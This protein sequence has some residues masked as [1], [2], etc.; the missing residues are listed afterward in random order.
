MPRVFLPLFAASI[1]PLAAFAQPTPPA[2]TA[3]VPAAP[4]AASPGK[5]PP[6][7][8]PAKHEAPAPDPVAEEQLQEIV[9]RQQT[10]FAKAGGDAPKIDEE[11]FKTQI[12]QLSFD[13]ESLLREHPTAK[14]YA[15]FGYFLGKIDMRRQS[16]AMLL[17]SNQLDPEQ[18]FVKNQIGNYLA[19]DGQPIEAANYFLAAIQLAPDEPLYHY[20]LGTLL[21]EARDD[22]LKSGHWDRATL[23]K[24]MHEAFRRAAELAPDR[25][26]FTYRYAESFYD[27]EEPQWDA[28][29]KAWSELE[30]KAP[31]E[32][33]RETMRLHAANIFIKTGQ[34]EKAR[35]LLDTVREPALA[36][37][38]EK[39]VAQLKPAAQK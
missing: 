25:I 28:A 15:A 7:P 19:E 1:V 39:L 36:A 35:V 12:Q 33:E 14:G 37:Q 23:D 8:E 18:P 3:P 5:L 17:K 10:L 4:P 2:L 30:E 26:E 16:I 20:Q 27:L 22:F 32:V 21:H 24:T 29:L 34:R 6:P 13:Y 9:R 31:N 11:D 38:K